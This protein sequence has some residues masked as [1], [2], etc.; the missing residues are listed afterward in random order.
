[1]TTVKIV[2]NTVID[3]S[4]FVL[5]K[6]YAM[7]KKKKKQTND[8]E[9]MFFIFISFYTLGLNFEKSFLPTVPT[10][11]FKM[12]LLIKFHTHSFSGFS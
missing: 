1:M 5:P 6:M 2:K 4:L 10:V 7:I 9:I 12:K 11:H 3:K 8:Q